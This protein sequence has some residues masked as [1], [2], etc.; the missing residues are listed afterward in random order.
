[1]ISPAGLVSHR[2]ASLNGEEMG[3]VRQS[4]NPLPGCDDPPGLTFKTAFGWCFSSFADENCDES[5]R[6]AR[7]SRVVIFRLLDAGRPPDL[8]AI[9]AVA[10]ISNM[11]IRPLV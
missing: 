10:P 8:S 9:G 6:R 2:K 4:F 5:K 3:S 11:L 7:R 1:M